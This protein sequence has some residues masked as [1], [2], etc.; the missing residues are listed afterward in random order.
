M[1][2][3]C[4]DAMSAWLT[5]H[6]P[7]FF[8]CDVRGCRCRTEGMTGSFHKRRATLMERFRPIELAGCW[9]VKDRWALV[10]HQWVDRVDERSDR[11]PSMALAALHSKGAGIQCSSHT[12]LLTSA[13]P[14]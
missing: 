5:Y 10:V 6:S 14:L 8:R 7:G 9:K 2:C 13:I 4:E 1:T 3:L 11:M 12:A